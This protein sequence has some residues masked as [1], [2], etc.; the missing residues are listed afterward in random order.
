MLLATKYELYR[1]SR[2]CCLFFNVCILASLLEFAT[3]QDMKMVSEAFLFDK[4]QTE[5][6]E[7]EKS[8]AS[9]RI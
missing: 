8:D 4:V 2:S 3:T 5:K 6:T 7:A 9:K 1:K